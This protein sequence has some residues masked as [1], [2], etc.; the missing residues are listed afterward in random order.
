MT[1]LAI[2]ALGW[3]ANIHPLRRQASFSICREARKGY[4]AWHRVHTET[5]MLAPMASVPI[6]P[7]KHGTGYRTRLRT[8][9]APRARL[10]GRSTPR[11]SGL[12]LRAGGSM[13]ARP[14]SVAQPCLVLINAARSSPRNHLTLSCQLIPEAV[15]ATICPH[16]PV[17][18]RNSQVFLLFI[19][20]AN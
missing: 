1:Q 16:E 12:T 10:S 17:S 3:L 19:P 11:L 15:V 5:L 7:L 14:S 4:Q 13:L 18:R 9:S 2:F 20:R 6:P 8:S